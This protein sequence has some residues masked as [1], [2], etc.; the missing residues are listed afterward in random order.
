MPNSLKAL[1]GMMAA[2]GA[3]RFYAKKL[4][5]NDNSKNQ[6]YLGSGF[7]ALNIIPHQPVRTDTSDLAGSKRDRSKAAVSF[8][9]VDGNGRRAAPRVQLILY[10][11]YPAVRMS[12]FLKG[13]T[14]APSPVMA[15]RDGGRILFLGHAVP[16]THPLAHEI[17][18]RN[19]LKQN[20]V[21]LEIPPEP[22]AGDT[23]SRLL[24]ALADIYRKNWIL[25]QKLATDGTK[26]PYAA[27]NGGGYT[28]EAEL[29]IASNSSAEPDYLGWAVKQYGVKDFT[30]F[31][32]QIPVTLMTPE[33]TGGLY[34]DLGVEGF[35]RRFSYLDKKG[36][37]DRLNFG[38]IY[39]CGRPCHENT[40]L[41]LV[42]QGYDAGAGKITD[43]EGGI[44]L[45]SGQDEPAAIWGFSNIM[46]HWNRKH[47]Q[48]A[49]VPSLFQEPPPQYAYG[50]K[51]LL[52]EQTDFLLFLKAVADGLVCYDPAIKMEQA[53]SSRPAIKRRSQ[54]RVNHSKLPNLYHRH[55]NI[56]LLDK[57]H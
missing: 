8:A 45:L 50:S 28:L 36:K 46:A 38:G 27:R 13:C 24:A 44:A 55:E 7:T 3:V 53:S 51:V 15:G 31:K 42:L 4:S 2:H 33:P 29:G 20:G 10:P 32:P 17:N 43:M 14:N 40:G 5:P 21:F 47:A 16:S 37:A 41:R 22:D 25:F 30:G 19:D 18:T 26:K 9:W 54:F 34:R 49:Y 35:M 57:S 48:A 56:S 6:V 52:C 12:G 11:D 39:T 1:V 23:R